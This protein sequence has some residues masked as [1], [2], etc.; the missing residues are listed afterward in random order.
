MKE[1][2]VAD[3]L[4][5]SKDDNGQTN[6][7]P[8]SCNVKNGGIVMDSSSKSEPSREPPVGL[9][10]TNAAATRDTGITPKLDA[11]TICILVP[12]ARSSYAEARKARKE[13]ESLGNARVASRH[14]FTAITLSHIHRTNQKVRREARRRATT[15]ELVTTTA[16]AAT[17][18][19][20]DATADCAATA[21]STGN[22]EDDDTPQES[23]VYVPETVAPPML[24]EARIVEEPTLVHA[25]P[26]PGASHFQDEES[27]QSEDGRPKLDES[28]R[29]ESNT[30]IT[31][32]RKWVCVMYGAA[33]IIVGFLILTGLLGS[34]LITA[35]NSSEST[36]EE[37]ENGGIK[38]TAS[39]ESPSPVSSPPPTPR[40]MLDADFLPEFSIAAILENE[41]SP[42][43]KALSWV[44]EHR[45]FESM[46]EAR[47]RQ[48]MALAT[49]FYATGGNSSW[50]PTPRINWLDDS[51]HECDWQGDREFKPNCTDEGVYQAI[52]LDSD[53]L[54][55]TIP[56]EISFLT[57][58]KCLSLRENQ[59]SGTL[60]TLFGRLTGLTELL[61]QNNQIS[62]TIPSEIG[63]LTHLTNLLMSRLDLRG[64]LPSELSH[65]SGLEQL[66][67]WENSLTGTIPSE[68]GLLTAL[69][70][71]HLN[72]N[73]LDGRLSDLEF[74]AS[75]TNLKEL[76]L[77]E[78]HFSGSIPVSWAQLSTL[79]QLQIYDN[80][81]NGSVP[82]ELCI[83]LTSLT[84]FRY[85]CDLLTCSCP[86]CSD[87]D[88]SCK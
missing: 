53:R 47:K 86:Q 52:N 28:N 61:L 77:Y 42:Q 66:E 2:S 54:V 48:L 33:A 23:D 57:G 30:S 1:G 39:S 26:M 84:S 5:T 14:S 87:K 21:S 65:L 7:D 71:L 3:T 35:T 27:G 76:H 34:V 15:V 40:A 44:Q 56:P 31:V 45:D 70:F 12:A 83:A 67:F 38:Q 10:T 4:S 29:S 80:L 20:F 63:A 32:S 17:T 55:G 43:A 62:G 74:L 19:S 73:K 41:T 79:E 36:E 82:E 78:N 18:I 9:V 11:A 13:A 75:L 25:E 51:L 72:E 81:V 46:S 85:D 69:T 88:E 59:I 24:L 58:L 8:G 22:Q 49:L 6:Q 50:Q 64:S 37:G 68:I 60:T 16:A